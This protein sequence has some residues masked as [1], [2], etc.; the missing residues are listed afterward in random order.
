[1]QHKVTIE[2]LDHGYI[3]EV[4]C[5]KVAF[6]TWKR[7]SAELEAYATGMKTKL[8]KKLMEGCGTLIA[9]SGTLDLGGVGH[10]LIRACE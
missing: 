3:V 2:E 6:E 5:K 8:N 9:A 4:G 1:M 7:A 10:A